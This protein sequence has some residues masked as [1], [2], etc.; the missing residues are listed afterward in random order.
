M[1]VQGGHVVRPEQRL[2]AVSGLGWISS[3]RAVD[4]NT[5]HACFGQEAVLGREMA[6]M[7]RAAEE[8][9]AS[10]A[11]AS[12][13]HSA[14]DPWTVHPLVQQELC[15]C[16]MGTE[17]ESS[18][19]LV[20]IFALPSTLEIRVLFLLECKPVLVRKGGSGVVE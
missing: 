6:E 3:D 1:G 11:K 16:F 19:A 14:L 15:D 2:A 20:L 7:E 5:P 9:E 18:C 4:C 10:L 17:K 8:V 12:L 13:L